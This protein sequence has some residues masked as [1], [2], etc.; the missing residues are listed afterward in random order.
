MSKHKYIKAAYISN[1]EN[2][3]KIWRSC[4]VQLIDSYCV[5]WDK[6]SVP[7]VENIFFLEYTISIQPI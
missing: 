5:V 2:A 1:L 6:S 7:C 4:D 3:F